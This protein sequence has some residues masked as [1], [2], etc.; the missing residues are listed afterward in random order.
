MR[1]LITI[2]L[3]IS[4]W[5]VPASAVAQQ[6]DIQKRAEKI[7]ASFNKQKDKVKEKSGGKQERYYRKVSG[8][9]A[10]R[11]NSE[12][13]SGLYEMLGLDFTINLQVGN[14]GKVEASGFEPATGST[15]TRRARKFR[16]EN[17]KVEGALLTGT[18]V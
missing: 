16:L 8:E 3:F 9:P 15:T 2:G 18:K 10:I 6:S 5:L 13:Y 4:F 17:A 14:D 1:L 12:A 11:Q 7:A